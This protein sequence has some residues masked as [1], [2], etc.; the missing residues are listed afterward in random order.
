MTFDSNSYSVVPRVQLTTETIL[1]DK[2]NVNAPEQDKDKVFTQE[3]ITQIKAGGNLLQESPAKRLDRSFK[4]QVGNQQ[5]LTMQELVQQQPPPLQMVNG[6]VLN[7]DDQVI[8]T[9][10]GGGKTMVIPEEA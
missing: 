7:V 4:R 5:P 8:P 1:R 3:E 10:V 2:L 6:A 9:H